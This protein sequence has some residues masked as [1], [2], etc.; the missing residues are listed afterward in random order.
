[1]SLWLE[2]TRKHVTS[3]RA[4]AKFHCKRINKQQVLF[5]PNRCHTHKD[6]L[7]SSCGDGL[8]MEEH[9]FRDCKLYVDQRATMMNILS[10]KSKKQYPK[11]V[12]ELLRLEKKR[13][14]QDVC[15]FINKILKV[16]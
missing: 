2:P 7:Y 11:S 12:T 8:Q 5:T 15:Y 1:V 10:E 9:I 16:T 13:F 3:E 14:V 4:K 6:I